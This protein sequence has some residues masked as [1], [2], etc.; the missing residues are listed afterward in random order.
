[1]EK[2]TIPQTFDN[3]MGGEVQKF[4]GLFVHKLDANDLDRIGSFRTDWSRGKAGRRGMGVGDRVDE[5]DRHGH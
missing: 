3:R 2:K 4:R 1:V 5:V